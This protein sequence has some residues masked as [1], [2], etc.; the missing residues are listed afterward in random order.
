MFSNQKNGF[1][2]VV[3]KRDP[4]QNKVSYIDV[5]LFRKFPFGRCFLTGHVTKQNML[6]LAAL[7]YLTGK[8]SS[9]A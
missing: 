5:F 9:P 3:S 6:E 4:L 2:G 1:L 7:R 8:V